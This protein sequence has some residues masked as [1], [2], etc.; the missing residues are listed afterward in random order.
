MWFS[1]LPIESK[2]TNADTHQMHDIFHLPDCGRVTFNDDPLTVSPSLRFIPIHPPISMAVKS[3]FL[4]R[5]SF[6]RS[7]DSV[8][9]SRVALCFF[10]HFYSHNYFT[11]ISTAL[12]LTWN[13]IK[14]INDCDCGRDCDFDFDFQEKQK[15]THKIKVVH[16]L[17]NMLC[18][19]LVSTNIHTYTVALVLS[20]PLF[21]ALFYVDDKHEIS[22]LFVC[23]CVYFYFSIL[24][25]VHFVADIFI[26]LFFVVSISTWLRRWFVCLVY[27]LYFHLF[28]PV[29]GAVAVLIVV[30]V[31][32]LI[33]TL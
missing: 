4:V 11:T 29:V 19:H 14:K 23:V 27:Y 31:T 26:C 33:S 2:H 9:F 21:H 12:M 5:F 17:K 15:E 22:L 32:H 20:G 13:T 30:A 18:T 1:C 24:F 3:N 28:V 6:G 16:T 8:F 25:G 10:F 7:P